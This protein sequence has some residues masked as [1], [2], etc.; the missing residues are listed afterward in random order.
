MVDVH[1]LWAYDYMLLDRLHA[2][3]GSPVVSFERVKAEKA[4]QVCSFYSF[5][6]EKKETQNVKAFGKY[7]LKED[8][9]SK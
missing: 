4:F 7:I 8:K 5:D 1:A 6:W 3:S 9:C 2:E